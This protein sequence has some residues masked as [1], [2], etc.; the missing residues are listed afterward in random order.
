MKARITLYIDASSLDG[1][2]HGVNGDAVQVLSPQGHVF[3]A[4]TLPVLD[5]KRAEG[6]PYF[7]YMTAQQNT[8][9]G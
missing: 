2:C 5:K 8:S 7:V 3:R 1:R 4:N 9:Q 6:K